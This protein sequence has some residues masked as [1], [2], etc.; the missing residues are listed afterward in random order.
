MVPASD[1]DI[2][3]HSHLGPWISRRNIFKR[4]IANS[5]WQLPGTP[6]EWPTTFCKSFKR[7][8]HLL[9]ECQ[10]VSTLHSPLLTTILRPSIYFLPSHR[11]QSCYANVPSEKKPC[12]VFHH[13]SLRR[14]L[15]SHPMGDKWPA[16]RRHQ[17]VGAL[18]SPT[19]LITCL[20]L[21]SCLT[22]LLL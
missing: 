1:P 18:H 21:P 9:M 8:L 4:S 15:L 11:L 6:C 7:S 5:G 14:G 13:A 3:L 22:T 20:S 12:G 19:N 16:D 2:S 10:A 17:E